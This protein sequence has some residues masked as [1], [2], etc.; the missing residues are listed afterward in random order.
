MSDWSQRYSKKILSDEAALDLVRDGMVIHLGCAAATPRHLL[1]QLAARRSEL[2]DVI[3]YGDLAVNWSEFD[4]ALEEERSVDLRVSHVTLTRP[5]YTARR[6]SHTSATIV[7]ANRRY[8]RI[9]NPDLGLFR[10]S[11]PDEEGRMSFGSSLWDSKVMLKRCKRVVA[12]IE[13]GLMRS[14]GDNFVHVDEVDFLVEV[15]KSKMAP[16]AAS[17]PPASAREAEIL[18]VAGAFAADLIQD[19]DTIEIGVGAAPNSITPHLA[20][21]KDLGYHSELTSPGIPALHEAGVFNGSRKTLDKGKLVVTALPFDRGELEIVARNYDDWIVMGTDY[22]HDLGVLQA[23]RQM[24][25]INTGTMIDLTGQIVFDS[26]GREMYTGPGGQIEFV[27]GAAY[28]PG[29]KNIHIFGSQTNDGDSR[30]VSELPRGAYV[31][32]PRYYTDF[33]VS[34]NGVASLMGK[35]DRERALELISIAHPDHQSELR[36][37]A[38][39][40]QLI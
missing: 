16:L 17:L 40:L 20:T 14:A 31:G 27:V 34:E 8:D 26:I 12:E 15:P 22:V 29:G 25:C 7:N 9:G 5:I 38:R 23:Q 28:S 33:V 10:L 19:G 35:T 30:I 1:P 36:D 6:L 39:R 32:T 37:Q 18:D 3:V 24:T 4:H 11:E 21:K 13:P 2:R